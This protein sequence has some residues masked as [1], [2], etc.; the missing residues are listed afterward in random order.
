MKL[1]SKHTGRVLT[2]YTIRA[3]EGVDADKGNEKIVLIDDESH[4]KWA[5][6]TLAAFNDEWEDYEDYEEPKPKN[7]WYVDDFEI[8]CGSVGLYYIPGYIEKLKEI[9]NYFETKEEAEKAVEKLKA[10]KRLKDNGFKFEGWKRDEKFCGDFTITAAD[11]TSC[12]DEDLD[13]LFG[14]D[15]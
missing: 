9:G 4:D 14:G 5:Y 11:Q 6:Y 12:D 13:L 3:L 2:K 15:E 1:Q 10:L 8:W 7:F